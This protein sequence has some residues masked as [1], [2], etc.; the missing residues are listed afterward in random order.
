M[1]NV[2]M[3]ETMVLQDLRKAQ[4]ACH[5]PFFLVALLTALLLVAG[6]GGGVSATMNS[7]GTDA[8]GTTDTTTATA[9]GTDS[10][11]IATLSWAAPTTDVDGSPLNNLSGY[12]VYYGTAQG[13]Y[14]S[15][16]VGNVSSYQVGGLVKG[17]TYYFT[18]TAYDANGYESD[19]ADAVSK[20]VS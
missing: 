20:M 13:V 3:S 19:Y 4:V 9:T 1:K 14:A 2:A 8:T 18:V 12:K 6:C 11:G 16:D 7:T 15:V 5:A 17:Q 10:T